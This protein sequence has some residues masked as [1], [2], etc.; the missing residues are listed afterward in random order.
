[1]LSVCGLSQMYRRISAL[2]EDLVVC[3]WIFGLLP[4]PG[5]CLFSHLCPVCFPTVTHLDELVKAQ[6]EPRVSPRRGLRLRVYIY[7]LICII[8]AV[9]SF[10]STNAMEVKDV[11]GVDACRNTKASQS[12]SRMASGQEFSGTRLV[13][14]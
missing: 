7:A 2:C 13:T 12:N 14:R 1:M 10:F 5:F 11:Q 3:I 8:T 9:C 6:E 4:Q